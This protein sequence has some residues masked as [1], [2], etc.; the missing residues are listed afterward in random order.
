MDGFELCRQIKSHPVWQNIPVL[1]LTSLD[2]THDERRGLALGAADFIRKPFSSAVVLARVDTH[3][4]LAKIRRDLENRNH[5]L[6]KL[7]AERTQQV[8]SKSQE[9]I[10]AQ[11]STITAFCVLAETRDNETGNHIKR[12]QNYV[13]LLAS[14]LQSKTQ[15]S[16]Y[17]TLDIIDLL[18][19][20]APLHDIGKVGIPD[21]IL[22]KPGRLTP[23]EWL[24]MKTHA[25][26]GRHAIAQAESEYGETAPS[27]FLTYAREIAY[28]HHEFWDG[29]GYPQGLAGDAI[30]LSARLMAVADVYDALISKRV[31]KP[32]FSHAKAIKI[33]VD[34]RGTHFDPA[35]VDAFLRLS[36]QFLQ[37]ALHYSDDFNLYGPDL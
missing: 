10:A 27:T 36:D 8:L 33:I 25:E 12:T 29:S 35:I 22:L 4:Q 1:F 26:L 34:Q 31:Y 13:R 14:H 6:E 21:A 23:D 11:S 32:A 37:I 28:C 15:F 3:L 7:V 9:V 24:I 20:S 16:P 19:R 5:D 2:E 30:P 17:L 18:Y